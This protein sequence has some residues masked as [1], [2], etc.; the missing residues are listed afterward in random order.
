M[1]LEAAELIRRLWNAARRAAAGI[2][3]G[4]EAVWP[5]LRSDLLVAHESIYRFAARW[6]AGKRVLDAACGTGYGSALLAQA[7]ASRVVG[8]DRDRRR[9]AFAQRRFRT[10]ESSFQVQDCE[11][12]D[13][14][15]GAFDLVVSSNTLEHLAR[16][17]RFLS[18]ARRLLVHD[19]VL[20]VA[21]PPIYGPADRQV[22]ARNPH[23]CSNLTIRQWAELFRAEG[24]SPRSF[25]HLCAK[26][27][28][29]SSHAAS[30][31]QW[32]DFSF[33]ELSGDE[34]NVTPTISAIYVLG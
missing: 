5:G 33:P 20:V 22:H 27:L 10:P 12:L 4:S 32:G 13:F 17:A 16:P 8:V 18:A 29:F 31:V 6:T 28:D 11:A 3:G 30:T 21:V 25:A 7:G 34:A 19:G 26:P 24:W 15:E 9:I 23:H 14:P 2:P 1:P